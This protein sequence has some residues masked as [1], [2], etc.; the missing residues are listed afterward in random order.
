MTATA[1]LEFTS[2]YC[3]AMFFRGYLNLSHHLHLL[4]RFLSELHFACV[5]VALLTIYQA[6]IFDPFFR[7]LTGNRW[8][9]FLFF[10]GDWRS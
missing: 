7:K 4:I 1:F 5:D 8:P 3:Y 10:L 2:L 6:S 9:A